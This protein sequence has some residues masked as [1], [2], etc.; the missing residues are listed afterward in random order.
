M[1]VSPKVARPAPKSTQPVV[2]SPCTSVCA[3]DERD[4]CIGCYRTAEEIS[5]W[6]TMTPEQQR[7]VVAQALARAKIN[8]PFA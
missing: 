1:S 3:L 7:Q 4:V 2:K 5:G 8:N 6:S